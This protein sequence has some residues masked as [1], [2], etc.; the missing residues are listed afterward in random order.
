MLTG[1]GVDQ[2]LGL[3]ARDG[4][5]VAKVADLAANLD[6]VLEELLKGGGILIS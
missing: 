1:V 2:D 5:Q 4:D 6:P 3:V